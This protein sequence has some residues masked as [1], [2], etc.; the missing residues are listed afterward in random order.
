MVNMPL[1]V[2][3][4]VEA[5]LKVLPT[6]VQVKLLNVV[7]PDIVAAE[8]LVITVVPI[9]PD[10]DMFVLVITFTSITL[11]FAASEPGL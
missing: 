4:L 3:S 7:S 6:V 11:A 1:I 10:D 9:L 5:K 8:Y 2:C